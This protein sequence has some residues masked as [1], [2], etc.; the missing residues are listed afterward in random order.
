MNAYVSWNLGGT[1]ARK[2]IILHY[3]IFRTR[4]GRT[5]VAESREKYLQQIAWMVHISRFDTRVKLFFKPYL[6]EACERRDLP[7]ILGS[8]HDHI[9]KL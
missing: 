4:G 1:T 3:G 8:A 5:E 6:L 2:L 7:R 9:T